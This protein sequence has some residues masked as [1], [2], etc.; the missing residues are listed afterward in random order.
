MTTLRTTREK[1]LPPHSENGVFA[2]AWPYDRSG[3]MADGNAH[4]GAC[5]SSVW[6]VLWKPAG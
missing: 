4:A 3:L 1:A 6:P 5:S 2:N